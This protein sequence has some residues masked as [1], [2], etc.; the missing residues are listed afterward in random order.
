MHT[1]ATL[2]AVLDHYDAIL[3]DVWGVIHDGRRVSAA[4]ATAL[5]RARARGKI[6]VLLTNAPKPRDPIPAQLDRLGFPRNAWDAVVTSGDAIREELRKRAP[7]PMYRIGPAS[8]Q[9][10]WQSIGLEFTDDL[11]GARF[12]GVSGFRQRSETPADY[13]DVLDQ[14]LAA[15]LELLCANPDV[16]VRF[17]D[18]LIWCA[19]ALA[20]DYAMRGGRVVQ[21]GKPNPPIY[22]LAYR[23]IEQ[24]LGRQV[25]G[26]R[27]LCIGDGI[28]TDV[29]GANRQAHDALFVASGMHG[30]SLLVDGQVDT[31]GVRRAL[32][33]AGTHAKYTM[34]SLA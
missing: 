20:R 28:E 18:Q 17:G 4:A 14:A 15:D 34:A 30:D 8:D 23:E 27:L 13:A 33:A 21:A 10:L 7:G 25:A 32:A 22:A 1:I 19:G 24:R 16:Q 29:A 2:D 12:L 5:S 9:L 31:E 6:V 3:C 26:L 11:P